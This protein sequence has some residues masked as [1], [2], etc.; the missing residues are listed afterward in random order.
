[1]STIFMKLYTYTYTIH[2]AD[3]WTLCA[4]NTTFHFV[5]TQYDQ[6]LIYVEQETSSKSSVAKE[7]M[8]HMCGSVG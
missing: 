4:R 2:L 5:E 7:I 6:C 3:A 1:M 8:E